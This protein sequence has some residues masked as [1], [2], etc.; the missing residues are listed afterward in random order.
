MKTKIKYTLLTLI[1]S[2]CASCSFLDVE[3]RG[4]S[5]TDTFFAEMEGLRTAMVGTYRVTYDFYDQYICKFAEV[6]G[7]AL[8]ASAISGGSDEMSY[9]YNFLSTPDLETTAVGYIWKKGYAIITNVNT[10]LNYSQKLKSAFPHNAA[11]IEQVEAN[12]YF[13]RALSHFEMVCCYAQPYAF[14]PDASHPGIPVITRLIGTNESI[15]RSSVSAVYTQIIHDLENA[16]ATLGDEAPTD[17]HYL[18]GMACNALLARV[19]L[20]MGNYQQAKTYADKV[21]PKLTLTSRANYEAMFTQ[22]ELGA[23]AIFRLSGF[24]AGSSL[25]KFYYY[26]SPVFLPTDEFCAL[27][28]ANDVR[29]KLLKDGT[30]AKACMKYCDLKSTVAD[31]R[32]YNL[33]VLRGSEIYLIRAEALCKL[34]KLDLAADDL[35]VLEARALGVDKS[36][37]SLSYYTQEDLMKIIERIRTKEL[38]FEGHRFFDIARWGHDVVRAANTNSSMKRLKYPDY[39]FAL[40]IPLVEMDVNDAM[41]QNDGY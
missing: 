5:D 31:N 16:A 1:V 34:N 29:L 28:A 8:Q 9:P 17:A 20:Y 32:Y 27:F 36:A 21:L 22:E 3:E 26:E 37:I 38:C 7:D 10:I 19:Y 35:K 23:E 6:A 11:E 41:T 39:R 12:A 25:R 14:T 40:P 24:S 18:S 15:A 4:K 2:L 30:G 33:T 13:L